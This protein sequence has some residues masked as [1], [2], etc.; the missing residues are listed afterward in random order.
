MVA[1]GRTLVSIGGAVKLPGAT[2]SVDTDHPANFGG[3]FANVTP[4]A[5]CVVYT[6]DLGT[7]YGAL[8]NICSLT[9]HSDTQSWIKPVLLFGEQPQ[10]RTSA[11]ACVLENKVV[12]FGG[13]VDTGPTRLNDVWIF[14]LGMKCFSLKHL[15][16]RNYRPTIT[17]Y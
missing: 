7:H 9:F 15:S 1:L 8:T 13:M 5:E 10:A 2:S 12:V 16:H 4:V 3:H 14:R 11:S 6:C 17:R